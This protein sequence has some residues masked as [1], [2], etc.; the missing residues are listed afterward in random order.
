MP[1]TFVL[2]HLRNNCTDHYGFFFYVEFSQFFLLCLS[3]QFLPALCLLGSNL[4]N[5][6]CLGSVFRPETLANKVILPQKQCALLYILS[7]ILVFILTISEYWKGRS[8]RNCSSIPWEVQWQLEAFL[9]TKLERL[10]ELKSVQD[11]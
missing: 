1:L 4:V 8:G 2:F 10:I 11:S 9:N 5:F 3:H 6:H 7:F